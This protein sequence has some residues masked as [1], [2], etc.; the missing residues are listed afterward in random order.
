M[1]KL[2][3]AIRTEFSNHGKVVETLK[4]HLHRAAETIDKLGTRT[5]VMNRKL[6]EVDV[7][8]ASEAQSLLG[9]PETLEPDDKG[10]ADDEV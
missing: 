6:R 9:L 4:T 8:P 7:L 3:S 5:N 1:W 2:L 10:A